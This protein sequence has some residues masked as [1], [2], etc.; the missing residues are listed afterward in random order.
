MA[1]S[2]IGGS[3]RASAP[4]ARY[5]YA[6]VFQNRQV[7]W[8]DVVTCSTDVEEAVHHVRNQV[9]AGPRRS[10]AHMKIVPVGDWYGAAI[11]ELCRRTVEV[12]SRTVECLPFVECR[13][14]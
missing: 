2:P 4:L 14:I 13:F 9:R 1:M 12:Q 3:A 7:Q 5:V 8:T 11:N 6:G 10:I